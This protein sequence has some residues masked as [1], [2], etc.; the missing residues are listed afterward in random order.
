MDINLGPGAGGA[1]IV[2]QATQASRAQAEAELSS[3][4]RVAS[5][6]DNASSFFAASSLRARAEMLD[7]SLDRIGL[8]KSTLESG[9]HG[10]QSGRKLLTQ[11]KSQVE[12]FR[13]YLPKPATYEAAAELRGGLTAD[14]DVGTLDDDPYTPGPLANGRRFDLRLENRR[15]QLIQ[16][17]QFRYDSAGAI[18]ADVPGAATPRF[19]FRTVGQL[20]DDINA[21][22]LPVTARLENGQLKIV[23]DDPNVGIRFTGSRDML[24]ALHMRIDR[25]WADQV[26][27]ATSAPT[28][29]RGV[30]GV[31]EATDIA[32]LGP[33][34][35]NNRYLRFQLPSEE[36]ARGY[37][38][39]TFRYRTDG[40]SDYGGRTIGDLIR[41][42]DDT[43]PELDARLENGRL[44]I[45]GD[46]R[47]IFA[48]GNTQMHNALG[49]PRATYWG[50][51]TEAPK[52]LVGAIAGLGTGTD[53][54]GSTG[55]IED[56]QGGRVR[57][58]YGTGASR[59]GTTLGDFV[60]TIN[61]A[62]AAG[63]VKLKAGFTRD[64]RVYIEST[65][66]TDSLPALRTD[67]PMRVA[68]LA[69]TRAWGAPGSEPY[70]LPIASNGITEGQWRDFQAIGDM[71]SQYD[72]VLRDS[73]FDG[74]NAATGD[75]RSVRVNERGT[76][77]D[78]GRTLGALSKQLG[79]EE[80]EIFD[81]I[82]AKTLEATIASLDKALD[83][84]ETRT[85]HLTNDLA[86]LDIR[87]SFNAALR[88][89]LHAGADALTLADTDEAGAK[90]LA[91]R[92]R[93]TL[94]FEALTLIAQG[95]RGVLRLF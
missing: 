22:N 20:V 68:G 45:E 88:N 15:G 29:I 92:T 86:A 40:R 4:L 53:A 36:S 64:G 55:W 32:S 3:G 73:N 52:R 24:E 58:L 76:T 71:V 94:A 21:S 31:T 6:V 78:I 79:I 81:L 51:M 39:A 66:G 50:G 33:G 54:R 70:V 77:L 56:G 10:L 26:R 61:D 46:A 89:T 1:L 42:I 67:R 41:F 48:Y 5:A 49:I 59:D 14:T 47:G 9:L 82:E 34:I 60:R 30:G 19:Y 35:A 95:E 18:P 7:G 83:T 93:E 16:R 38:E 91:A 75:L 69:Y 84:I 28:I 85:Q 80:I 11:L 65:G 8:A 13:K 37:T 72:S 17:A 43:V 23:A 90:V 44:V 74:T 12:A 27:P 87:G 2:L 25:L 63:T 57:F 62:E